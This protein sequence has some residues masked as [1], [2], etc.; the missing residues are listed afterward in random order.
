MYSPQR[1]A[2]RVLTDERALLFY[3]ETAVEHTLLTVMCIAIAMD[4]TWQM[5]R[6]FRTMHDQSIVPWCHQWWKMR[7]QKRLSPVR[8]AGLLRSTEEVM[9]DEYEVVI[10]DN[11]CIGDY[12]A[13]MGLEKKTIRELKA[14]AKEI[15]LKGYGSMNKAQLIENIKK[16]TTEELQRKDKT[17]DRTIDH[18]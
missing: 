5:G 10:S 8:C 3:R 15:R 14:L 18:P 7:T 17:D 16:W 4:W 1:E 9:E 11:Q 12:K 13:F 6:Q 2:L